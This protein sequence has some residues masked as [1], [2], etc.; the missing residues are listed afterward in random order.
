[1]NVRRGPCSRSANLSL[2]AR[3][4]QSESSSPPSHGGQG[5]TS[6]LRGLLRWE[7]SDHLV[8][9]LIPLLNRSDWSPFPIGF[10][11]TVGK[12]QPVAAQVDGVE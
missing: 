5:S 6:L 8:L 4:R 2:P 12:A 11:A 10:G 7:S 3:P 9:G 1:M